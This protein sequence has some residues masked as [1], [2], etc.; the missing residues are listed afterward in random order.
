MEYTFKEG[1]NNT[2]EASC[3]PWVHDHTSTKMNVRDLDACHL[4]NNLKQLPSTV[5]ITSMEKTLAHKIRN[6]REY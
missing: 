3:S 4:S 2:P 6:V 5:S 1:H